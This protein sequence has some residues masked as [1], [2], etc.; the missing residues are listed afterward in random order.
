MKAFTALQ[1]MQTRSCNENNPSVCLSVRP[2]VKR[3]DCYKTKEKSV[4]IFTPC[5]RT[6]ILVFREKEWL[7]GATSST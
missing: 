2:S 1:G 6:F 3:V 5:E 4:E 7:V